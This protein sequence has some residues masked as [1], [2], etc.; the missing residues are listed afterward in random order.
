M[1]ESMKIAFWLA[2]C[3]V[4]YAYAGYPMVLLFLRLFIHRPVRKNPIEPYV[5]L[6][7]PAYNE[8]GVIGAKIRNAASLDYPVNKLEVLIASDGS[9]DDTVEVAQRLSDGSRIRVLAFSQN[10][11][12]ISVLNDAVREARGEIIVFSDAS[13]ILDSDSIRQLVANFADPEVGAVSGIYRVQHASE[14]RLGPQ[15]EIYW[16]YETFLKIQESSLASILGGHG[17]ILGVRKDLYPY[18]AP[19][20]INDDYVIPVRVLTGGSRVVYEPLAAAFEEASEMVGF[21]RRV[22]IMAGNM[23]QLREIKGLFWPPQ[24]LPLFFFLSHKVVRSVVP[25][26]LVSLAVSNSFL[27]HGRF[28]QLTGC[29]QL[30]FY[31]LAL[32]GSQ[33]QLKPRGLRLPYYFCFVNAAYLWSVCQSF[34]GRR[35]VRWK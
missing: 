34:Q 13:A 16:K 33:W 26:F 8:S 25:F 31:G 14:A 28:Y 29:F 5:T 11:G 30:I 7:V 23:Q 17:Q 27:L 4:V 35:K 10:R 20:T 22:R 24:A 9:S 3:V 32:V 2:V 21:Q 19:G 12:K 6:V 15:E 18:P 1:S